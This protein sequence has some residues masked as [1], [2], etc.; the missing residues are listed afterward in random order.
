MITSIY[1]D[2]TDQ[3][4]ADTAFPVKLLSLWCEIIEEENA[5]EDIHPSYDSDTS[6]CSPLYVLLGSIP[7]PFASRP[8]RHEGPHPP[9]VHGGGCV[10]VLLPGRP[11]PLLL[12]PGSE[13]ARRGEEAASHRKREG[14]RERCTCAASLFLRWWDLFFLFLFVLIN[15]FT[16]VLEC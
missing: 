11:K 12:S 8:F 16:R 9:S 5:F 14:R 1:F 13:A 10:F 3:D 6:F 2:S 4:T 15:I 7:M